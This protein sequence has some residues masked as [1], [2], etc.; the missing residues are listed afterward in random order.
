M[1]RPGPAAPHHPVQELWPADQQCFYSSSSALFLC[2]QQG[3]TGGIE[4][5][6]DI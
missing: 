2:P 1:K 5:L 3:L 4:T 6:G